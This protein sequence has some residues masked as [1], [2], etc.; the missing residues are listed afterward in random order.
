MSQPEEPVGPP[1]AFQEK[2]PAT[3]RLVRA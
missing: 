1:R 2:I 3:G